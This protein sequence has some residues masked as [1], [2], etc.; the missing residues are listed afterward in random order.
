PIA[1]RPCGDHP[2]GDENLLLR[3]RALLG[4]SREE[5]DEGIFLQKRGVAVRGGGARTG[6]CGQRLEHR[7]G[8]RPLN[9][10]SGGTGAEHEEAERGPQRGL[11]RIEGRLLG[12]VRGGQE[13]REEREEER[14]IGREGQ[15][16]RV[17]WGREEECEAAG[18]GLVVRSAVSDRR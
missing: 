13:G 2:C 1:V 11:E 4:R 16:R 6:G 18:E 9:V 5:G 12:A 15:S 14:G 17:G 3:S 7:E 10:G 8:G